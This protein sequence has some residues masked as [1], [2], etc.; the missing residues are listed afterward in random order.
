MSY[1]FVNPAPVF[2]NLAGTT[3]IPGGQWFFYEIG[4]TTPKATY[5]D[6][7]LTTPNSN[8]VLLDSS[9]RLNTEVWLDGDYTA[10]L[11]DA[12]DVVVWNGDI[13]SGNPAGLEIPTLAPGFLTNDGS[14][15]AWEDINLFPDPTGSPS[16]MVVVNGAGDGYTLQAQPAAVEIPDPE[17]VV[18]TSSVRIGTSDDETKWFEQGGTGATTT[19]VGTKLATGTVT[20][21][22]PF[23][24]LLG[25][26]VTPTGGPH[27][28]GNGAGGYYAK[29]SV[30]ASSTTAFTVTMCTNTGEENSDGNISGAISFF[31]KA[32]GTVEVPA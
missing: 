21:A 7:D 27:A 2:F 13:T 29:A 15:L 10:E 11:Q 12:D 5:S 19:G 3:P 23:A 17:V 8:P 31:W 25:V 22:T 28:P 4:T 30:T 9:A 26:Q 20:F 14:S 18:T 1:R 16:Y 24:T 6:I 32:Y